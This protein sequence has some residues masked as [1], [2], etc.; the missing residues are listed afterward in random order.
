V[1]RTCDGRLVLLHDETID[2]TTNETGW[3]RQLPLEQVQQL[4]A[5][6]GERIPTLEEALEACGTALG[7]VAELKEEGIGMET[8]SIVR[9]SGFKGAVIYA[10]FLCSELMRIRAIDPKAPVM[11]L[12]GERLDNKSLTHAAA[13]SATHVGF[14]Y[15]TLTPG[16]VKRC[17]E[18]GFVVFAYTVNDSSV[19][20]HVRDLRVDGIISDFP[21]RI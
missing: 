17:H 1:R 6:N 12:L 9:R 8:M 16:L 7:M 13:L 18:A 21:D 2:R 4:N 5:G 20:R 15:A 10:S 14:S 3:L 11:L 19:I